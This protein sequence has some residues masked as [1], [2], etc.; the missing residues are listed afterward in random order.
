MQSSWNIQC[1]G[2]F[3]LKHFKRGM[4]VKLLGK[5]MGTSRSTYLS[6]KQESKWIL[7][8]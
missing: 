6:Y 1:V 5:I 4:F 8:H 3:F 2:R 7:P